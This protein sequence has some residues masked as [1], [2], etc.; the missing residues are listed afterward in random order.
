V[1]R[2]LS[3][4]ADKSLLES[5][6]MLLREFGY[7]VTSA[8]GASEGVKYC[9]AK[10]DLLIIGHSMPH[11]QKQALVKAFR[12]HNCAPVLALHRENEE[13]LEGVDFEIPPEPQVVISAVASLIAN[14]SASAS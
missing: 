2:I 13:T 4:S 9:T 14:R 3:V 12:A 8:W 7:D 11:E 5:R 1:T 10:F 6:E